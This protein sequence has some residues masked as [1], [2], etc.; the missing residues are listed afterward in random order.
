MAKERQI[1]QIPDFLTVRELADSLEVSPIEVMK[2]L[3][4]NGIMATINQS[5]DYDTAA[6]VAEEMGYEAQAE[7]IEA[8][9]SVDD[10]SLPQWKRL[11]AEE[12][13]RKLERRPPVVTIL[14][15]VDHGK[16]TLLD[17]IRSA[18]VADGEA[19]GI[20]QHIGAYQVSLE[21]R[22]ITFLD[23][24]GHAAFTAMRARGA[25]GADVAVL[26]VAADDGVME[27][28]KEAIAHARAARI[29][30]VV[31]ITKTDKRNANPDRVK[32]ELSDLDLTPDEWGGKTMVVSVSAK[33]NKGVD[34]LLEAI[35]MT[36]EENQII[37]NPKGKAAG[38]II[39]SEMDK[40]KGIMATLLVQNGTLKLGDAVVSGG[41]VGR[42][43]AMFDE[44]GK[45]LQSASPSTPVR[46][47]GLNEMP[48][49]GAMFIVAK[50]ERE[51][52]LIAEEWHKDEQ[53]A[54][55]PGQKASFSLDDVFKQFEAGNV[56]ELN[57]ILKSDV[58]GSLE[59]IMNELKN[60]NTEQLGLKVLHAD[61]GNITENDVNL[62]VASHAIV[63]GFNVSIDNAAHRLAESNGV[64]IRQ[65]T[66]IYQLLEDIQKALKGLLDPVYADK[67]IGFAEVKALFKV[68]G[69]FIAGCIVRDGEI[70]RNAKTR[71]RR[72]KEILA[73]DLTVA[74]IKRGVEDAREVRAGIECGIRLD[75]FDQFKVGD[76]IDFMIKERVP[77]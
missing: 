7:V 17:T 37:A 48:P 59:P 49:V 22:K 77:Q 36:A 39:E 43:R 51:A 24:P 47:M 31:A 54:N 53:I 27:T 64:D 75:G 23:T 42:I 1:V 30:I 9:T 10:E 41:A 40:N 52:R 68:Q 32:Q 2:V 38:T 44:R 45:P 8:A 18:H 34:D 26:V 29:P 21:G 5:I 73:T 66:I 3:I 76:L 74:S 28:T 72:G 11:Y 46:V 25:Q 55:A 63:I 56:K 35:L 50:N 65:Y 16:T 14:G 4:R 12:D 33:E 58:Q 70:R 19:G 67:V 60:L 71:V 69:T 61:T 13:P 57:L 62:A 15:H 6:I 20:T